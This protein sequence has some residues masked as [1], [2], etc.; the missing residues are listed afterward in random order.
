MGFTKSSSL[1]ATAFLAIAVAALPQAPEANVTGSNAITTAPSRVSHPFDYLPVE[2]MAKHEVILTTGI[3][4]EKLNATLPRA[5]GSSHSKRSVSIIH[6]ALLPLQAYPL[7][8]QQVT[9]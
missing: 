5:A 2:E 9:C 6:T 3:S 8:A 1:L 4:W 7:S